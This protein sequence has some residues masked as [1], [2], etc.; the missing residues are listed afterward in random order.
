M[1]RFT[2]SRF[3]M[4]M[5]LRHFELMRGAV[6]VLESLDY[7]VSCSF[8][9]K[10]SHV[11][12]LYDDVE[13]HA[14][15]QAFIVINEDGEIFCFQSL[16]GL[17]VCEPDES[18]SWSDCCANCRIVNVSLSRAEIQKGSALERLK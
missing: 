18:G 15:D 17:D 4:I 5:R 9:S 2:L 14:R 13:R 7:S 16:H 10:E 3:P 11:D 1:P 12:D 8:E 6:C